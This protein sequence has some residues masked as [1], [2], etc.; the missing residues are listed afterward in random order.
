MALHRESHVGIFAR[1]YF[2]FG[3]TKPRDTAKGLADMLIVSAK[4]EL[5]RRSRQ[6][7]SE[8]D[9]AIFRW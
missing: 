2:S 9:F 7:R 6:E 5:C 4:S 1:Q 3:A 8:I